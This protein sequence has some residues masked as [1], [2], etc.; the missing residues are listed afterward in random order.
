MCR[1]SERAAGHIKGS[2][3]ISIHQL[4]KR[5]GEVPGGTVWVHYAGGMRAGIAASLLDSA[6]RDAVAV[7]D[8][9]D[10]VTNVGLN[11][12]AG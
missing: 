3:H 6:G 10:S 2:V 7:D 1:D 11:V 12:V 8:G 4:H 9:F 5:L